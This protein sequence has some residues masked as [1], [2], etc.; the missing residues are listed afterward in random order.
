MVIDNE[1]ELEEVLELESVAVAVREK[2]PSLSVEEVIE[3]APLLSAVAE[4]KS[5][6]PL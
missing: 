4:P 1:D 2:V 5:V 6:D 3:N